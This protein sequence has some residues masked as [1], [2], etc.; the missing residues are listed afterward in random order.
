M[1]RSASL[2]G[3]YFVVWAIVHSVLASLRV[4]EGVRS[5]LGEGVYRWYRF[6]FV[7]FALLSFAPLLPMLALL[8]D[9]VLYIVPS[10]WRWIMVA[11]QSGCV[12]GIG[13]TLLQTD[14][15]RFAGL[16]ALLG[17]GKDEEENPDLVI[18]GAYCYVRHPMYVF[19]ILL[20]WLMPA[21]TVNLL[22]LFAL[23]TLYF[24]LGSLHEEQLLLARFGDAYRE[25]QERVP[26]FIPR[27][28]CDYDGGETSPGR[29]RPG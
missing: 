13:V 3:G 27:L 25:Y 10:P 24:V 15:V 28:H 4:K 26:R 20:I 2:I 29:E 7:I 14:L 21:M 22:V 18:R 16:T 11:F 1:I 17:G 12:I 23:F 8:P 9:R 6:G 5:T 19:S